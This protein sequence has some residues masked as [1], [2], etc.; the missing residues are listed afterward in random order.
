MGGDLDSEEAKKDW[1]RGRGLLPTTDEELAWVRNAYNSIGLTAETFHNG[2]VMPQD[3]VN[4]V[5]GEWNEE[6]IAVA[7]SMKEVWTSE[8]PGGSF[9]VGVAMEGWDKLIPVLATNVFEEA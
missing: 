1:L 8:F 4:S 9:G 5:R 6:A 3:R 7:R 2:L